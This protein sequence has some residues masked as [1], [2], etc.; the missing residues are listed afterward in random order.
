V[1]RSS[2][3]DASFFAGGLRAKQINLQQDTNEN[4][5]KKF[6]RDVFSINLINEDLTHHVYD[7]HSIK[8]IGDSFGK[9][10]SS[11][12]NKKPG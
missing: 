11:S 1:R 6:H 7:L 3:W 8:K 12:R 5:E 9:E 10:F 2:L 4:K